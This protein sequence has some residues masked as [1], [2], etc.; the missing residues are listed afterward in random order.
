MNQL[1]AS[2]AALRMMAKPVPWIALVP[3]LVEKLSKPAV[4]RPYSEEGVEVVTLNSCRASMVGEVSSKDEPF[5]LRV[6]LAPSSRTSA[7]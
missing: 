7:P 5:S 4:V 3:D 6:M 2:K 1:L